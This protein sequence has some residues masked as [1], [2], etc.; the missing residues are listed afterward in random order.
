ME[1]LLLKGDC[2]Q[3]LKDIDNNIADLIIVDPPYGV[4][5]N[6]KVVKKGNY[7]IDDYFEWDMLEDL[8]QFTTEWF[9]KLYNKAKED[10]F[11]YIFW[12]QKYMRMGYEI[13]NPDRVIFWHYKNLT[14]GGN[15]D[16]SY[17]Y[18]PIFV[19]KKGNPKLSKGKHSSILQFTKPQSN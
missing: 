14:L 17:D 10:S 18:D 8:Q 5:T 19:V 16:F 13:F 4:L 15:G 2:L 3:V 7:E 12:S 6:G 9:E 11:I 1:G